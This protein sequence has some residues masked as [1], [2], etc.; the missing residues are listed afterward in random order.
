MSTLE[1]N[2]SGVCFTNRQDKYGKVQMRGFRLKSRHCRWAAISE[3]DSHSTKYLDRIRQQSIVYSYIA[4]VRILMGDPDRAVSDVRNA[5]AIDQ[6]ILESDSK[7][8]KFRVNMISSY[9]WLGIS[10]REA[11]RL[12]ESVATIRKSLQLQEQI[13][14]LDRQN[15]GEL[16][17]VADCNSELAVVLVK[18]GDSSAAINTFQTAIK[19]YTAVTKNDPNDLNSYHQIYLVRRLMADARL[20]SGAT[21][22]P[23]RNF[24][25]TLVV[26][27]ELTAKDPNNLEW[28]FDVAV[29]YARIGRIM[30]ILNNEQAAQENLR[31]AVPI[32]ETLESVSPQ[33]VN[34]IRELNDARALIAHSPA[35]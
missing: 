15:F 14:Q 27:A 1:I 10:L 8:L 12:S 32:L 22:E 19:Q 2:W 4:Y 13:Y 34:Y 30:R 17:S 31:K 25:E 16:N 18:L 35:A 5:I 11:G 21:R 6:Y 7:N 26:F 3:Y 24:Q 23:L 28:K 9:L 20:Q 29:C 33:N